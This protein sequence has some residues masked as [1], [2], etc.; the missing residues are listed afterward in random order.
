MNSFNEWQSDWLNNE[1]SPKVDVSKIN[2]VPMSFFVGSADETCPKS[3]AIDYIGKMRTDTTIR[4]V[5]G[6]GHGFFHNPAQD[7]AVFAE[8]ILELQK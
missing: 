6:V 4:E 5:K 2:G 1:S 3:T 8:I 7:H